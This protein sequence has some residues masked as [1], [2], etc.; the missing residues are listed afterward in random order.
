[1]FHAEKGLRKQVPGHRGPRVR[2]AHRRERLRLQLPEGHEVPRSLHVVE[3]WVPEG[4]GVGPG[5]YRSNSKC[6][7][8]NLGVQFTTYKYLRIEVCVRS[9]KP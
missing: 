7:R 9:S 2:G 3:A 1:M 5:S 8:A 6:S 4:D